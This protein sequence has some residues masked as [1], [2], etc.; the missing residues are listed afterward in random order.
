MGMIFTG[1]VS[2]YVVESAKI[3]R[4]TAT[5]NGA[6]AGAWLGL[7]GA[8]GGVTTTSLAHR[9]LQLAG[10]SECLT[11]LSV[12]VGVIVAGTLALWLYGR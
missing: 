1:L 12:V 5:G 8:L 7:L 2:A 6:F 3:D 4:W 10:A 11:V 9:R